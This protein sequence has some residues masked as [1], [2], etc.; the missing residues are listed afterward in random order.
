MLVYFLSRD[1]WIQ[2]GN[3]DRDWVFVSI[4]SF[5]TRALQFCCK[6]KKFWFRNCS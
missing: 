1:R 5:A 3:I 6:S 2:R 4:N